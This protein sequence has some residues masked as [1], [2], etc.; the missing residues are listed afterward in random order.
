M[1]FMRIPLSDDQEGKIREFLRAPGT[2]GQVSRRDSSEVLAGIPNGA[3]VQIILI[4]G[5]DEVVIFAP[6]PGYLTAGS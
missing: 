4:D 1:H 6:S 2:L 3:L 5:T